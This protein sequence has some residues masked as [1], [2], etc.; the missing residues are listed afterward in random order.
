MA[1]D[2]AIFPDCLEGAGLCFRRGRRVVLDGADLSLRVGEVVSLLGRNGAGKTTLLRLMMGLLRPADG[3]V[4]LNGRPLADWPKREA[5]KR[6]AY[7]PQ[8]HQPPFPYLVRDVVGLGRLPMAGLFG[9]PSAA[10][11]LAVM[12][13]LDRLD[14]RPLADRPYTALSG[15]ERQLVMIARAMAQGARLLV[16]DEP[17]N[18]LDYGHQLD[19]LDQ[20]AD[21]AGDG[22]G[23]LMTT[24]HPDQAARVSTRV[25]TLVDG[26]ID[27]NGPPSRVVTETTLRRLYGRV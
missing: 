14:I 2:I 5:A 11:T 7:V 25:V 1:D 19:L 27:A 23:V 18:G 21:L 20:I 16:M 3:W 4:A 12:T 26:R 13:V 15:G 8:S 10:D 17:L 9:R 22:Y 24:H 6:L